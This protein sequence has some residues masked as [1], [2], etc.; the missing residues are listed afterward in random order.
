MAR[1]VSVSKMTIYRLVNEGL[2]PASRVGQT[3]R[4]RRTAWDEYLGRGL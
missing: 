1:E 3:I 2:L 4:V